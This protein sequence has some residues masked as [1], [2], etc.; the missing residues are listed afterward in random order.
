MA[1]VRKSTL[2]Y[3]VAALRRELGGGAYGLCLPEQFR[4]GYADVLQDVIIQLAKIALF[5]VPLWK[6]QCSVYG[7]QEI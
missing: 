6:P 7:L 4:S 5:A 3:A 2:S 1:K